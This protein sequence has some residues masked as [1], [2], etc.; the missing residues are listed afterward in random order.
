MYD[1]YV[2]EL[3]LGVPLR[4]IGGWSLDKLNAHFWPCMVEAISL[5]PR[6]L[7]LERDISVKSA[8]LTVIGYYAAPLST[9]SRNDKDWRK[10]VWKPNLPR[11]IKFMWH[12]L[13]DFVPTT[14]SL[15]GFDGTW[16]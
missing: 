5:A 9:S 14:V 2:D 10:L 15:G 3:S 11:S 8:Y 12:V 4:Y 7:K 1:A 16:V 13:K 6:Y